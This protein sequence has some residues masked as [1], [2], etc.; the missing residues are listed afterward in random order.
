MIIFLSNSTCTYYLPLQR[1]RSL[2]EINNRAKKDKVAI[3][4]ACFY[5]FNEARKISFCHEDERSR[6]YVLQSKAS[7]TKLLFEE[8]TLN[9]FIAPNKRL[10]I[11]DCENLKS[12]C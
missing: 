9:S 6:S 11:E 1:A 8:R 3:K 2:N 5:S 12:C 10:E 7:T 4:V